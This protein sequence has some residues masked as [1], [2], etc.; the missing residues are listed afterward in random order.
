MYENIF[1]NRPWLMGWNHICLLFRDRNYDTNH[2]NIPAR[3]FRFRLQSFVTCMEPGDVE[4]VSEEMV[5][6][7]ITCR[8]GK[9]CTTTTEL[10]V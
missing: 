9:P 10:Y 8:W 4:V 2:I 7:I 1:D 6:S 3:L 5:P